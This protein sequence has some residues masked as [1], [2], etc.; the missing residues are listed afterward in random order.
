MPMSFKQVIFED[1]AKGFSWQVSS[2]TD[3]TA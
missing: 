3:G 2:A 1:P